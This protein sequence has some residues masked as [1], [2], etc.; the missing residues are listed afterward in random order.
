MKWIVS[1]EMCFFTNTREMKDIIRQKKPSVMSHFNVMRKHT[2]LGLEPC[3]PP[4]ISI[5]IPA[6]NGL[7]MSWTGSPVGS[8]GQRGDDMQ[9][10]GI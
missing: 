1:K 3:P 4:L 9:L 2:Q 6:S 7:L 10:P 8:G 5:N